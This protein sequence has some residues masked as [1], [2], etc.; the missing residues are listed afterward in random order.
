ME[1]SPGYRRQTD[2]AETEILLIFCPLLYTSEPHL[3]IPHLAGYLRSRGR[4]VRTHDF[5][6]E[7]FRM[8]RRRDFL[9]FLRELLE[10]KLHRIK[11]SL[12]GKERFREYLKINLSLQAVESL[13]ADHEDPLTAA[14]WPL[15]ASRVFAVQAAF[16][17]ETLVQNDFTEF[18]DDY[19]SFLGRNDHPKDHRL[20]ME[21]SSTISQAVT[22]E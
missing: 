5:N 10:A 7:W 17:F 22:P 12:T 9:F 15:F 20:G 19:F 8:F 2:T 3:A 16:G 18:C 1:T 6:I 4:R 13:L 14:Q 21:R 11:S